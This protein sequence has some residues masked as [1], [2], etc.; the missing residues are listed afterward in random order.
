VALVDLQAF[1]DIPHE[2]AEPGIDV[3]AD[4]HDPSRVEA[5]VNAAKH[6]VRV[7]HVVENVVEY[8]E[9]EDLSEGKDILTGTVVA[10]DTPVPHTLELGL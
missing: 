2:G 3:E 8:H 10:C 4:E 7:F 6:A 5:P 9:R 1:H